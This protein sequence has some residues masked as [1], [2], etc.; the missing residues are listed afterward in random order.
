VEGERLEPEE[1][2]AALEA[3]MEISDPE[4]MRAALLELLARITST[5]AG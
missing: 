2:R 1:I 4:V 3:A 5:D